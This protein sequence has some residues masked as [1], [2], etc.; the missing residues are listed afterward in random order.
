MPFDDV[1]IF[2]AITDQ[3]VIHTQGIFNT[4]RDGLNGGV[5]FHT[6]QS[7]GEDTTLRNAHF[8]IIE[9]RKT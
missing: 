1:D 6:E 7:N 3:E 4:R 5:N 8:L 9:L 2:R